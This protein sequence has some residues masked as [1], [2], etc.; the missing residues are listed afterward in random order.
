MDMQELHDDMD[1]LTLRI[2]ADTRAQATS[3]ASSLLKPRS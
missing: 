2:A 3:S 1:A